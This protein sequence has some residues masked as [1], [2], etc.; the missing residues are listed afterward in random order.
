MF[1]SINPLVIFSMGPVFSWLWFKL[2]QRKKDLCAGYK[3]SFGANSSW[4]CG[5]LVLAICAR[6]FA[7]TGHVSFM[8]VVFTYLF[9]SIWRTMLRTYWTCSSKSFAATPFNWHDDLPRGICTL[10]LM[11]I[12]WQRLFAKY[13][14]VDAKVN[15]GDLH[16]ASLIYGNVFNIIVWSSIGIGVILA[17][18][19]MITKRIYAKNK[20][21]NHINYRKAQSE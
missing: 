2:S 19:T 8:W 14:S 9:I 15:A 4:L 6:L 10:V 18:A 11:L 13:T 3:F 1:Q 17:V 16:S 20:S 7:H 21:T 12:I 5:F